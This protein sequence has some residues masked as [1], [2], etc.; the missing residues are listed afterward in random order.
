MKTAIV[1][2]LG[3]A[4][5][6][7]AILGGCINGKDREKGLDAQDLA[8]AAQAKPYAGFDLSKYNATLPSGENVFSDI[9]LFSNAFGVRIIGTP[10]HDL[11]AQLMFDRLKGYGLDAQYQEFPGLTGTTCKN[12]LGFKWGTNRSDWIVF[13]AHYDTSATAQGSYD[14]MGGCAAVLELARVLSNY[15]FTKTLVFA[16]WDCEE[17]GL[18]GSAYFVKDCKK[19]VSLTNFNYDCY[20][21]NYPISNPGAGT[22]L[23]HNVGINSRG[24]K[25]LSG[26]VSFN[27]I[28]FYVAD[29]VMKIPKDLQNFHA[30][31]GNSDH[32]SF[33]KAPIAYFYGDPESL[34][35]ICYPNT[36]VDTFP[37]Y[38][39]AAGG[40]DEMKKGLEA[41]L[42]YSYYSAILWSEGC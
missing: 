21:L 15:N 16:L 5:M 31:S 13:G 2:L 39:A 4:L 1:A 12:V 7:Q 30:P 33:G 3:I 6:M 9:T 26:N 41:P 27:E 37:T 40:P 36:P 35:L 28:L 32:A 18:Y 29:S 8:P 22:A 24:G 34:E 10:Q 42:V 11:A 38:V 23:R 25:N 19:N 17:W 14:N 20:G